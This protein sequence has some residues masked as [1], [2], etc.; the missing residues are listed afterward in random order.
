MKQS[1]KQKFLMKFFNA[2]NVYDVRRPF[3]TLAKAFGF[4]TFTIIVDD[5]KKNVR[6]VFTLR[7][8]ICL[9][10]SISIY[11]MMLCKQMNQSSSLYARNSLIL[12]CGIGLLITASI[13]VTIFSMVFVVYHRQKV[14]DMM[15]QFYDFD[16]KVSEA[17]NCHSINDTSSTAHFF[18]QIAEMGVKINHMHHKMYVVGHLV[19]SVIAVMTLMISS[20]T[21]FGFGK[22]STFDLSLDWGLGLLKLWS[23][24]A[25]AV[26]MSQFGHLILGIKVRYTALNDCFWWVS[27]WSIAHIFFFVHPRWRRASYII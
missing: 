10:F 7:D 8:K 24:S 13:G 9:F 19:C 3:A 22:D 16:E 26:Q 27:I 11:I 20:M 21:M 1:F 4:S 5:D 18:F 6:V 14:L 15:K 2:N 12:D 23:I 17:L 25:Y